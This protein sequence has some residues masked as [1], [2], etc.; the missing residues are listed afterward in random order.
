M[1]ISKG[2]RENIARHVLCDHVRAA[3]DR[4]QSTGNEDRLYNTVSWEIEQYIEL[5]QVEEKC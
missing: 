3:L 4:F 5:C 1:R 2:V